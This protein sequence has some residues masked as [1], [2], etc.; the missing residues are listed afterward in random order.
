MMVLQADDFE[1]L[2]I[3]GESDEVVSRVIPGLRLP[4]G[5]SAQN[6][7]IKSGLGRSPRVSKKWE[8]NG[9][10][11]RM[12]SRSVLRRPLAL[13]GKANGTFFWPVICRTVSH[14]STISRSISSGARSWS[15]WWLTL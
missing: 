3:Y 7:L 4:V 13:Y 11:R 15:R 2:E 10:L 5:E 9:C 1:T 6:R 14:D 8:T 12:S